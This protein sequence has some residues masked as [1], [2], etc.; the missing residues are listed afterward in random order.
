MQKGKCRGGGKRYS[1]ANKR[2][3]AK[4]KGE[5]RGKCARRGEKIWTKTP[6]PK[7]GPI[8]EGKAWREPEGKNTPLR[9]KKSLLRGTTGGKPYKKSTFDARERGGEEKAAD[10]KMFCTAR[11]SLSAKKA[12]GGKKRK[13]G[14]REVEDQKEATRIPDKR[15]R[16]SQ[17]GR[18]KKRKKAVTAKRNRD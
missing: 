3:E 4:K 15:G 13:K 12:K 6:L 14:D 8:A 7:K 2:G 17:A 9:G 11:V 16:I 18:R 1:D 10:R 5:S